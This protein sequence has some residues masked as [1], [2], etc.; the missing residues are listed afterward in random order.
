MDDN[1]IAVILMAVLA[2]VFIAGGIVIF[3]I[4]PTAHNYN[5]RKTRRPFDWKNRRKY[6]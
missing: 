1:T 4:L 5:K 3:Y 6:R 2:L